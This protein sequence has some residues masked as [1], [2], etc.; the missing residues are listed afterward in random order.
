MR[1][2]QTEPELNKYIAKVKGPSVI[3]HRHDRP[4]KSHFAKGLAHVQKFDRSELAI[5]SYVN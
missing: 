4:S 3:P 2:D 1:S 5:Y